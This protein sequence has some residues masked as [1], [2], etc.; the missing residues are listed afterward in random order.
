M[1]KDSRKMVAN[2]LVKLFG[3]ASG[4]TVAQPDIM[5]TCCGLK[6]DCGGVS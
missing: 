5:S 3:S 4:L 6:G 2:W 1:P